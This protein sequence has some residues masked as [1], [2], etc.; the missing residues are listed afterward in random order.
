MTRLP[1]GMETT[2]LKTVGKWWK[3]D[4]ILEHRLRSSRHGLAMNFVDWLRTSADEW[5]LSERRA[6]VICVMGCL[7]GLVV[8]H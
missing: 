6:V 8:L 1:K 4:P 7:R 2:L 5:V 3:C